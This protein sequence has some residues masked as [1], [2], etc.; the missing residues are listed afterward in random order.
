MRVLFTFLFLG[1]LSLGLTAQSMVS[2]AAVG[3]LI[4][5]HSKQSLQPEDVQDL[6]ID[7]QYQDARTGVTYIYATQTLDG[8]PVFN[9][10]KSIAISS[11]KQ[12]VVVNGRFIPN[13]ADMK[14]N[15]GQG[16][17]TPEQAVFV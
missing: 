10:V 4:L 16:S 7:R 17:F 1:A 11:D 12:T 2:P 13:I 6:R 5:E 3:E 15:A 8:I 14:I 9:A